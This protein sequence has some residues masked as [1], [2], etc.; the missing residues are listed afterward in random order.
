VKFIALNTYIRKL[1][2]YFKKFENQNR[3]KTRSK[4]FRKKG[5]IKTRANTNKIES[6]KAIENIKETEL[7]HQ[8]DK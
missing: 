3:I 7:I 2:F 1:P 6:G 5:I 4:A 8:Q